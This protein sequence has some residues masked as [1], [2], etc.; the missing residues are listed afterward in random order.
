MKFSGMVLH[1]SNTTEEI[2][3]ISWYEFTKGIFKI[4]DIETKL[5][6]ISSEEYPTKA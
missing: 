5:T 4:S 3:G 1:F 2:N 6:P